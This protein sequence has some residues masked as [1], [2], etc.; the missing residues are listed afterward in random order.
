MNSKQLNNL[1]AKA[2]LDSATGHCKLDINGIPPKDRGGHPYILHPI[3]VAMKVRTL[4]YGIVEQMVA[5]CHDLVE[6]CP[7]LFPIGYFEAIWPGYAVDALKL[8]THDDDD[9]TYTEYIIDVSANKIATVV[10]LADIEDNYDIGRLKG[11]TTKDFFR[12][13]KYQI[14]HSFLEGMINKEQFIESMSE[15]TV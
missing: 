2:F 9:R 6:D 11:L 1:L 4:G 7:K 15:L 13:S 3:R 12:I 14:S 8:L 10:K 5:V